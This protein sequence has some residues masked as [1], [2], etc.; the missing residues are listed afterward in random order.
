MST[1]G[2]AESFVEMRGSL[3]IPDM[4]K[5][6]S[7]YEIAVMHG[8]DGTEEEWLASL[9]AEAGALPPVTSTDNGK[10]LQVKNGVWTAVDIPFAEGVSV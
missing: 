3:S 2:K 1:K 8:F 4:I 6:A 9:H 10:L 5:G 7:A